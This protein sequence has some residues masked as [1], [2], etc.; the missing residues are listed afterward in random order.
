MMDERGSG[1]DCMNI[2]LIEQTMDERV[3]G[4][5]K[6]ASKQIT[7]GSMYGHAGEQV[8]ESVSERGSELVSE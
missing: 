1:A 2:W 3:Y 6:C 7:D 8:S 5:S 4:K